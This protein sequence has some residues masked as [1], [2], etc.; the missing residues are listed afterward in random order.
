MPHRGGRGN[1]M[2]KHWHGSGEGGSS[3]QTNFTTDATAIIASVSFANDPGTYLRLLG[4]VLIAPTGAGTFAALDAAE[5]TLGIGIVSLD[6]FTAGAG[7]MPDPGAEPQFDWM[8]WHTTLV[9]FEGSADAPGS[10]IALTERV[11]I[12]SKA[13]RKFKPRSS[14]VLIAEY[15]DVA[16][17]PPLS[18]YGAFRVLVAS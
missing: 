11:Q 15:R 17:A 3:G 12:E 16:G 5:V 7:S 14:L 6:A 10:E 13:M 18:V 9:N 8:W 1:R 4:Q 2:M